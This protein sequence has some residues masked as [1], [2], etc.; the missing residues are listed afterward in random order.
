MRL[1]FGLGM[2][3]RGAVNIPSIPL[4]I[5]EVQGRVIRDTYTAAGTATRHAFL[6]PMYVTNAAYTLSVLMQGWT[7][8][9]STNTYTDNPNAFSVIKMW[10]E[11]PNGNVVLVKWSTARTV[12]INPGDNDSVS[13]DIYATE[14]GYSST[15]P[16]GTYY[17]KGELSCPSAG[18]VFPYTENYDGLTSYYYLNTV[19]TLTGV[20]AAGALGT[21][22]VAPSTAIVAFKPILLGRHTSE[23]KSFIALG[24]SIPD[25]VG[26]NTST[27]GVYG[28][29]Y[30]QRA[31]GNSGVSAVPCIG[32]YSS[33][34][35]AAWLADAST[36]NRKW[37]TL[38]KYA[39]N[40]FVSVGTNDIDA[41][42]GA[43]INTSFDTIWTRLK[44][45]SVTK[46]AQVPLIAR[47]T[48]TDNWAT[49]ANQTVVAN[50]STHRNTVNDYLTTKLGDATINGVADVSALRDTVDTQKWRV[51]GTANYMAVDDVHPSALGHSLLATA[52]RTVIN[53]L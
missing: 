40:A 28:F 20:D 21:T 53:A 44:A 45:R 35:R 46:I 3:N 1:G 18:G 31:M 39:R 19:T 48:S 38:A 51:D 13:D 10:I 49:T 22:G 6:Q 11:C 50:W 4:R 33:G 36:N 24:D 25:G 9:N 14:A 34:G 16:A 7:W 29:G 30:M 2:S 43:Q 41:F 32:L 37:E 5:A 52:A 8:K 47:T 23:P 12:T 26:D 42:T 27:G 15:F 17:I